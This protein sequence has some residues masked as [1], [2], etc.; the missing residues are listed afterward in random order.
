MKRRKFKI[1]LSVLLIIAALFALSVSVCANEEITV[2][3]ILNGYGAKDLFDNNTGLTPENVKE[4][5]T[6]GAVIEYI[7]DLILRTFESEKEFFALTATAVL[8]SAV[9]N[10]LKGN[11]FNEG[12]EA[13]VN[14]AVMLSVLL[15]LSA[16][17]TDL[18]ITADTAIKTI[19]TFSKSL[20]PVVTALLAA[21]GNVGQSAASEGILFAASE[22]IVFI[23]ESVLMPAISLYF[24]LAVARSLSATVDLGGICEFYRKTVVTLSTVILTVFTGIM[25]FQSVIAMSG[26]SVAKSGVKAAVTG[27]VPVLG[28]QIGETLETFLGCALSAKTLTGVFGIIA[29]ASLAVVPIITVTVRYAAIRLSAY[30]AEMCGSKRIAACLKDV[31]GGFAMI[32]AVTAG[33]AACLA[34][35]LTVTLIMWRG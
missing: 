34:A 27:M 13:T 11:F 1:L 8:A 2:P 21:S 23:S 22:L 6:F 26:D 16:K 5:L 10:S 12:L 32:T 19:S 33:S 14:S 9:F 30:L 28:P 7:T 4:K 17:L 24:A 15:Y 31:S 35:C 3:E 20:I 25:S 29:I 18:T